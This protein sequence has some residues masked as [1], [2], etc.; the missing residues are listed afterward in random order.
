[1]ISRKGLNS[2]AF[3]LAIIAV[4]TLGLLISGPPAHAQVAGATL[5]GTISD[6]SGAAIPSAQV[7]I[8]N[9]ATGV[10]TSV[11]ADSAGF[12]SAPN[13]QPGDYDVTVTAPGF[14]TQLESNITLTV[15]AQQSLNVTMKVGQTTEKIEVTGAAPA[16]QLASS[17]ISA[18]VNSTT[19]RELP[20]NG[21][22]WTS[23]AVLEPG[24]I[25]IR[26]QLG[27]SGTVNRGN[28]GFGNQLATGGHRPQENTYRINGINVNDYSNGAPGSVEGKQL[29]VDAIQEFSVLTTNYSAEYG[30]TSGGVINA[31]LKPGTNGFHGSA[32][33]F[34]RNKNLDARNFFDATLPPFHRNQFGGSVG[35]PI[36]KDKTFF[37]AAYEGIRQDKSL[38]AF[39]SVPS[40]AARNGLLCSQPAPGATCTPTQLQPNPADP[41]GTNAQG[42]DLVVEKYL[43]L[44]PLPDPSIPATSNGDVGHLFTAP[45]QRYTEDYITTRIDH[46]I[47]D[48]DSLDGF[49]F[50]D[51]SPQLTP[52]N[53]VLSTTETLSFR[54]MFGLEETHTFSATAVNAFRLGYNR[55]VGLVGQ[56]GTALQ[57]IAADESLGVGLGRHAP[58]TQ[59]GGLPGLQQ[60]GLGSQTL[61]HHLQNSYQIYDDAFL[62]RGLHS[63][64][65]GG[66][67]ERLQHN[68]LN[69]M[70]PNGT[71]VF[72]S[73]EDFLINN[74]KTLTIGNPV[75]G[76]EIGMR[77]SL[78]GMYIQD[79]WRFRPNLTLNIGL[80]Y[81]P[82]SL[83]TEVHGDYSVIQN[84][85][86][87]PRVTVQHLWQ[88][89]PTLH[90]FAPRVGFAWDPSHNGKMA[91]RGGFGIFD[92]LPGLWLPEDQETGSYPFAFSVSGPILPYSFAVPAANAIGANATA[93]NVSAA[94]IA[95]A[96]GYA[97]DQHPHNNYAMN[98][99][100]NIQREFTP[101]LAAT[102]GYVGSHTVHLPFTTDQSNMVL[103]LMPG[104][105]LW[106]CGP[107]LING[108][109]QPGGGSVIEPNVGALRPTFWMVSSTYNGLQ[110]GVTKKMS[111]GVQAQASYTWGK[112]FDSSSSGGIGDPFQNSFT[113]TMFFLGPASRRGLCDFNID[114]NLVVNYIWQLPTPKSY[115]GVAEKVLG[116]W[117][118]GGIL[119]LSS[120][121]PT[122]PFIGGDP[123]GL[124]NNDAQDYP[125]RLPGCNPV[126]PNWRSNV[127]ST[128]YFNANCFSVPIA[129]A[130]LASDPT[131]CTP[132][133]TAAGVPIP[134]SCSELF[135]NAGRN[136]I[137]GP[138]SFNF[139]FSLFKNIPV[140]KISESF[141]IQ[142]RAEFFNIFN[143]PNFLLP[144]FNE[145]NNQ[146]FDGSQ[147]KGT[148]YL[149]A[150][151]VPTLIDSTGT[152]DP[153][154]IQLSLKL[155]W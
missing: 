145:G 99:N 91:V 139:D 102:L 93:E 27:T 30:R 50:Y 123:L 32:F 5:S 98:W 140:R 36:K 71:Y 109:C 138:N 120:G 2:I 11:T 63:L 100:F 150:S 132:Y 106:Q 87:G 74:P 149:N 40:M 45:L 75:I 41:N 84:V 67:F 134:G 121:I 20:L 33:W 115:G 1:M 49:W 92:V 105:G 152:Y 10:A 82:T 148:P 76:H 48:K 47:S 7:S 142:F 97:P 15:G 127:K 118:L 147:I 60:G 81:E 110:A 29:G 58:I 12:Y 122:T 83:P 59:I 13:L 23:L 31:I 3:A 154:Q 153:R 24:V 44:Y 70:R 79:D 26:S 112:C 125:D 96:Q 61:F 86:G 88:S 34:I 42:I 128:S 46:R 80:R 85:Y 104:G 9:K 4:L 25:G 21:R 51:K 107:T 89:N 137:I 78:W 126:N 124:I 43:P 16:V 14:A 35:G 72:S 53:F 119:T 56:P 136:S 135:G 130:S 64:K 28:R 141:N 129:P 117:Q 116:G 77:Q 146:L 55:A 17:T 131:K 95:A 6:P 39:N 66:A 22:D 155:I 151:A 111:H 65:I 52:D 69:E 114:Q 73:L 62:T 57:P 113:S 103:P 38:S 8:Q 37:F 143:H 19:V 101:T 54:T 94:D 144:N 108:I 133:A 18:Q 90:N 68:S